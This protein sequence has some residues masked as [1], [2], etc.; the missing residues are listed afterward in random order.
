M[1]LRQGYQFRMLRLAADSIIRDL[2]QRRAVRLSQDYED[3]EMSRRV[4]MN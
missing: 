1:V 3:Y 2:L 4:E